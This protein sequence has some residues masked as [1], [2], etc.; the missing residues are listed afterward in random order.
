MAGNDLMK[1]SSVL[2][3]REMQIRPTLWIHLS[4][5]KIKT[6]VTALAGEHM[7]MDGF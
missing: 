6:R 5:A 1:G 3:T 2:A 4:M 7:D